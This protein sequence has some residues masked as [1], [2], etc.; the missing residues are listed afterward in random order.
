MV[1]I[2]ETLVIVI[3]QFALVRTAAGDTEEDRDQM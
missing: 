3:F 2:L 1:Q